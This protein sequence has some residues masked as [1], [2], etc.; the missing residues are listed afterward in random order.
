MIN[1]SSE[2][3]MLIPLYAGAAGKALLCQLPEE[4]IDEILT[5]NPPKKYT[6]LSITE[7]DAYKAEVMSLRPSIISS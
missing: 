2:I 3:G 7:V 1:V 6:P 5:A 4:E